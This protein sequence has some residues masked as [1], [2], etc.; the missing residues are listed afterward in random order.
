M[1]GSHLCDALAARDWALVAVDNLATSRPEN[2]A[3]LEGASGF[4]FV[5]H[6]VSLP[7]QVPGPVDAVFH[8]ASRASPKDFP[9]YPIQIAKV[10]TIGTYNLLGLA[11]AK[12]A[13]FVL[14]STSEVYGDPE[15]HPQPESYRG[16]VNPVGVR[17]AYDE[18]KR[19]AEAFTMAYHRVHGLQTRIA[20]IFNTHGPRIRADDGRVVP[21]FI[22]QA[23][24]GEPLTV[25]GDGSQTRSLCYVEDLVGGLLALLEADDPMPFNLGNPREITILELAKTVIELT[26]SGSRIEF[27][28]MPE[29]DPRRRCP[30]IGRARSILG[31]EPRT[32]LEEGLRRTID[33]FRGL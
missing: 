25:H 30:D 31:W 3:Q 10:N 6:D 26:G 23:L 18:A 19:C 14:A 8:L 2:L 17:G 9:D 32:G 33:Y 13:R 7:L 27:L 5:R 22:Q 20:R 28:P 4:E 29:D 12:Q 24:R 11:K 1:I 15:V 16:N 21:N